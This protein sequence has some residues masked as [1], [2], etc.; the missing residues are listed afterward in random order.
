LGILKIQ[1][2]IHDH[3][4]DPFNINT[5]SE[6]ACMSLRTFERRLKNTTG[7]TALAYLQQMRVNAAKQLLRTTSYS[8]E[9]ISYQ[10]GY[11]NSGSFRKVFVKWEHLLTSQYRRK[12]KK[13]GASYR[14]SG[15]N[16]V[17]YLSPEVR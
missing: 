16:G 5:L 8:F 14:L 15:P 12:V 10:S 13:H 1:R 2:W 11:K 7:L 17:S 6:S 9:E 3:I 4:A